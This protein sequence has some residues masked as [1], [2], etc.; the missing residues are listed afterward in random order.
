MYNAI[1][2]YFRNVLLSKY[3]TKQIHKWLAMKAIKQ[4][5]DSVFFDNISKPKHETLATLKHKKLP[6]QFEVGKVAKFFYCLNYKAARPRE[7]KL[8]YNESRFDL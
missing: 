6:K 5:N 8:I 1:G 3:F 2:F 7:Y 4:T